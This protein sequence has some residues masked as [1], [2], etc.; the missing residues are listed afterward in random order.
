[1]AAEDGRGRSRTSRVIGAPRDAVY[2]AF[3]DP[4]AIVKWQAPDAMT[5]T[6]HA[7][8]GRVGGGYEMSLYYPPSEDVGLGKSG[9]NED[10]YRSRFVELVPPSRIVQTIRFD[11]DDPRM[12]GEFTMVVTLEELDGGTEVTVQFEGIPIGISPEDNDA[13]TRLSLEK[14]ARYVETGPGAGQ[15][16]A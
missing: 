5:A 11:T 3:V 8:D 2:A 9:G 13:G 10:R 15:V 4:E 14:L 7:F 12:M 16:D 6:V 1:M